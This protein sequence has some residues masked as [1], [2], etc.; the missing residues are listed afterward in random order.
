MSAKLSIGARAKGNRSRV[1]RGGGLILAFGFAANGMP[2]ECIV[3]PN[4]ERAAFLGMAALRL[5]K[6][7][8]KNPKS[9]IRRGA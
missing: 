8:I 7:K 9:K 4:A 6:S 2:L 3:R 5:R 1:A